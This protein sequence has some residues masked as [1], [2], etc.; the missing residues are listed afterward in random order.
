MTAYCRDIL[1]NGKY[2]FICPSPKCDY[3]W[4]YFLVRHV[5]GLSDEE[6][7]EFEQTLEKNFLQKEQGNQ[8]CPGCQTWCTRVPGTGN[9]V[10]CPICPKNRG[11]KF[12]FCWICLNEWKRF[13]ST[14]SCGNL[15]CDGRDKR[16]HILATCLTKKIDYCLDCPIIRGCQKCGILIEHKDKCGHVYC[17]NCHTG[18]CFICL[19]EKKYGEWQCKPYLN[20]CKLAPRQSTLPGSR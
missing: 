4:E 10:R 20:T 15:G 8:R 16:I 1:N 17:R 12:D 14:G 18:F 11:K 5:A 7:H 3:E 19:K 9:R 2:K 6:M 13:L